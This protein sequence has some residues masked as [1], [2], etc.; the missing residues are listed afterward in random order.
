MFYMDQNGG[1]E[2]GERMIKLRSILKEFKSYKLD[3]KD[4]GIGKVKDGL[5]LFM[6]EDGRMLM[7]KV[8]MGDLE[9][10]YIWWEGRKEKLS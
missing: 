3:V 6:L 7:L 5:K 9:G 10:R 8:E 1:T 4:K 2:R